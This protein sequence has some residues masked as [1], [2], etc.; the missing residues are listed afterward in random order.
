M[1]TIIIN[2]LKI[3]VCLEDYFSIILPYEFLHTY[4]VLFVDF[5]KMIDL[6]DLNKHQCS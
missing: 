6:L 3:I 4:V 5:S 2:G 1:T